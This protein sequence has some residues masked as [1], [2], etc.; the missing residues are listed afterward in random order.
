MR[1]G[2]PG[3]VGAQ[4]S[5]H[6]PLIDLERDVADGRILAVILG[7]MID[8]DHGCVRMR[9]VV[10]GSFKLKGTARQG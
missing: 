6:L 8:D 1:G 5:D 10:S 3:P 7:E 4:E 9:E 2:L